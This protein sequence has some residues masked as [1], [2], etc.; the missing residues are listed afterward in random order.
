MKSLRTRLAAEAYYQ[1]RSITDV[2]IDVL[3]PVL[4]F[5]MTL[6]VV[7]FLMDVRWVYSA[8]HDRNLRFVAI[9]FLLGIVALNRLIAQDGSDES[10]I[11]GIGL[12]GAIGIYTVATTS[13][14]DVGSFA[15]PPSE[16][17]WRDLVVNMTIVVFMWWLVNRLTHECCVDEDPTAG[18]IG[19][20]TGTARKLRTAMA[21]GD[22][23]KAEGKTES[24]FALRKKPSSDLIRNE[25]APYDPNDWRPRDVKPAEVHDTSRRPAKR[26]PGISI[27]YFSVP[28]MM[29]FAFGLRVTAHGGDWLVTVGHFYMGLYMVCALSLLMLTSLGGLREYFRARRVPIPGAIGPF[30]LGTGFAMILMVLMGALSIPRPALPPLAAVAER[31]FDPWNKSDTFEPMAVVQTAAE[32]VAQGRFIDVLSKSVL[33]MFIALAVY[34]AL[35]AIGSLAVRVARER[36]RFPR[37]VVRLLGFVD[38][39][40]VRLTNLPTLP[41]FGGRRRIP[42]EYAACGAFRNPLAESAH[43]D[44]ARVLAVS[45]DAL[46]ALADD[47]GAPRKPDTTPY[48]FMAVFPKELRGLKPAAAELVDMYVASA[49]NDVR[50]TERDMDRVRR[51]W[52]KYEAVRRRYTK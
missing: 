48:E 30:W 28:V 52:M 33:A 10:Y 47:V 24:L 32:R 29:V 51:F 17:P 22:K 5:L 11:Y 27:L 8:M 31:R 45:F 13:A 4:I 9:C 40:L 36:H 44:D 49:Y 18:E 20:L 50:F 26:H 39:V 3:T 34:A 35:R 25:I 16:L 46:C 38:R 21:E 19:I 37:W 43:P 14:Y 41:D 15:G 1:P 6:S 12:A 42:L 2:L 7:M 23:N